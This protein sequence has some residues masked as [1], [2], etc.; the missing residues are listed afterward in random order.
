MMRHTVFFSFKPEVSAEAR[1]ALLKE[2]T[3]FPA[4]FLAMRD[5]TLGAN[6]SERDDTFEY[7]FSVEFESEVE[8]KAYLNSREHEE[9][10]RDRFRP[11][12]RNRAIVSYEVVPGSVTTLKL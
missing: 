4:Q 6:Q 3:T 10:V 5:F 1:N 2:Y 8:L 9:H 7:A 12:I 11:L